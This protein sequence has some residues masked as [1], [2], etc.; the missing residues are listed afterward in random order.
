MARPTRPPAPTLRPVL[1]Q[2][3][4]LR[5]QDPKTFSVIRSRTH[6]GIQSTIYQPQS[7]PILSALP[8]SVDLPASTSEIGERSLSCQKI[9]HRRIGRELQIKDNG[10]ARGHQRQQ[11]DG[12]PPEQSQ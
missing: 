11:Q 2:P 8:Q 5:D 12:Q 10:K 7:Y 6:V 1:D 9:R 3:P 4:Q